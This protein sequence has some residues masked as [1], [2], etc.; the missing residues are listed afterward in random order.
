MDSGR[1]VGY[2]VEAVRNWF[3]QVSCAD[4]YCLRRGIIKHNYR[5]SIM[6]DIVRFGISITEDLLLRF[7]DLIAK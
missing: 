3:G 1:R 5:E 4:G 2:F 7:D 6:A